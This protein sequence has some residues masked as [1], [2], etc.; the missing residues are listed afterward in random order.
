MDG[1]PRRLIIADG[2]GFVDNQ[3]G[4]VLQVD[5]LV[6]AWNANGSEEKDL[7]DKKWCDG[8]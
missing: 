8:I 5:K 2:V 7:D 6:G 4:K 3:G 1:V